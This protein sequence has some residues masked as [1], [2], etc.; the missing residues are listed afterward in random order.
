MT[1]ERES[2]ENV[3]R[4][5]KQIAAELEPITTTTSD[6]MDGLSLRLAQ[7]HT[8][9]LIDQLSEIVGEQAITPAAMMQA[10]PQRQLEEETLHIV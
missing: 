2:I 7:A 6:Q 9:G 1:K 5:A 8:L 10:R 3:L 4:L